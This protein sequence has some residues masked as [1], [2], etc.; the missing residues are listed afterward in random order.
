M[1]VL[2]VGNHRPM[3]YVNGYERFGLVP[4]VSRGFVCYRPSEGLL[5]DHDTPVGVLEDCLNRTLKTLTDCLTGANH[6]DLFDEFNEYWGT[7]SRYCLFSL[8]ETTHKPKVVS[9]VMSEQCET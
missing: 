5:L 4:H 1:F 8:V 3:F 7:E 6:L 2:H 9:C